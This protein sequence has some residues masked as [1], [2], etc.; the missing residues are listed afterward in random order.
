MESF[1]YNFQLSK[2]AYITNYGIV[3]VTDPKHSIKPNKGVL[4]WSDSEL[5]R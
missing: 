2:E 3:V 1:A 4:A 5:N